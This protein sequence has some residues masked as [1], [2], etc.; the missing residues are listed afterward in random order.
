MSDSFFEAVR[1]NDTATVKTV[2]LNGIDVNCTN[3]VGN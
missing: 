2:L 3:R 1:T